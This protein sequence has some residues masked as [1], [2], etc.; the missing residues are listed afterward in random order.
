M[1]RTVAPP[2]ASTTI[3]SL[4]SLG[5]DLPTALADVI[6]NSLAAGA[7]RVDVQFT[8]AAADSSVLVIDNGKGM[9]PEELELAMRLG[10]KGPLQERSIGDHGR[11][12]LGLKTASFSQCRRMTVRSIERATGAV[13]TRR[14]DLDVV[15]REDEWWLEDD[16]ATPTADT[17]LSA[18]PQSGGTSVLWENLDRVLPSPNDPAAHGWF[19]NR[20]KTTIEHLGMVFGRLLGGQ[21]RVA[22]YVN[23]TAVKPW[24]P[25]MQ[26]HDATL[27]LPEVRFAVGETVVR[28]KGFVLPHESRLSSA[29]HR[30]GAGPRGWVSQQGAYVYRNNR[31]LS[32]G[33]WLG[34]GRVEQR[35]HLARVRVDFE[36]DGDMAWNIDVRK[37]RARVPDVLKSA[38]RREFD[39]VKARALRVIRHRGSATSPSDSR[40]DNTWVWQV[41]ER[42]KGTFLQVNREHPVVTAFLAT[43]CGD[44]DPE[45]LLRFLEQALPLATLQAVLTD[46]PIDHTGGHGSRAAVE[47]ELVATLK[48]AWR[49]LVAAG[50]PSDVA[51]ERLLGVDPWRSL[52]GTREQI[53]GEL[54]G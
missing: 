13:S 54:D 34:L 52:S 36:S 33:G 40:D 48:N 22:I 1:S 31:L 23:G 16:A 29:V 26:T 4:R 18:T 15:E 19:D 20:V 5:Y 21:G 53:L 37:A 41:L 28:I 49:S 27:R 35:Y 45:M 43:G 3:A 10:S 24:D 47:E 2:R 38:L 32:H 7:N 46:A 14:W 44:T 6:D 11:F 51:L 42:E 8:F 12:G 50:L 17:A 30:R 9:S 39:L 25:F